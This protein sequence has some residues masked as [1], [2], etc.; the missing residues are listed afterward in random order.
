MTKYGQTTIGTAKLVDGGTGT[1][2]RLGRYNDGTVMSGTTTQTLPVNGGIAFGYATALPTAIPATGIARFGVAAY[3]TPQFTDGSA[4]SNAALIGGFAIAFGTI[5]KFGT[6]GIIT[7]TN[8]GAQRYEFVTPGGVAAPSLSLVNT[9]GTLAA[10]GNNAV[11]TTD[12]R[13]ASCRIYFNL[14]GGGTGFDVLAGTY[15]V[16]SQPSPGVIGTIFSGAVVATTGT[17]VGTV[18][19]A[20]T[21]A[22]TGG[23]RIVVRP[24]GQNAAASVRSALVR[25]PGGFLRSTRNKA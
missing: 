5:P 22:A 4:T 13:C 21:Q 14:A 15:S 8:G 3:T 2:W 1:N 7:L 11:T 18:P 17:A 9:G 10:F 16:A 23:P 12:T 25:S 6:E 20:A 19:G 24:R